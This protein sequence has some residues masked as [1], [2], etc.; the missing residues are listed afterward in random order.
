MRILLYDI[1]NTPIVAATFGLFDQNI[2]YPWVLREWNLISVAY[3]WIDKKQIHSI[4]LLD[5]PKR[6]A[7]NPAD[8]YFVV[9]KLHSIISQADVIVA[10]NG[11]NF[12]WKKF[13][14]RVVFHG[15]PPIKQPKMV[16][17][18]K[19]ARKFKFTSNKLDSLGTHLGLGNKLKIDQSLWIGALKGK[20]KAIQAIVKYNRADIPP[21]EKLYL[22]LRPYVDGHP[23]QALFGNGHEC[24]KCGSSKMQKRGY[25]YTTVSVFQRYQ[26]ND[27]L[28]WSRAKHSVKRTNLR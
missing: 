13:M 18:L 27:C 6:F 16:D 12:D 9:K 2:S 26:C 20:K 14:A 19:D 1:E 22:R 10:H 11:N 24:P 28:G 21:L 5:D 4:S 7:K 17:T 25:Y 15:L 3:K 8:D 23:N